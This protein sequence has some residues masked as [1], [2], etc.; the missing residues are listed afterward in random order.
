MSCELSSRFEEKAQV[1]AVLFDVGA[2]LLEN[3]F[4]R[5]EESLVRTFA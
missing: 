1:S 5:L 3:P 2:M 4:A